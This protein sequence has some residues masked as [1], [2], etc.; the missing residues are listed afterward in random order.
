[1]ITVKA[2]YHCGEFKDD[3]SIQKEKHGFKLQN[4]A[5]I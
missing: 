5:H 4:Q 1:M 2:D 3:A